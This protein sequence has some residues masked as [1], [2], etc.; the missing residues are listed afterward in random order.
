MDVTYDKKKVILSLLFDINLSKKTIS[1]YVSIWSMDE[2][3]IIIIFW[4]NVGQM[5]GQFMCSLEQLV[6]TQ[7]NVGTIL[8]KSYAMC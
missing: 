2:I 7:V 5:G 8:G 4:E 1:K 3:F 6:F